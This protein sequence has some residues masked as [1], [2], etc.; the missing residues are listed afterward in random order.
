MSD[1]RGGHKIFFLDLAWD[2]NPLNHFKLLALNVHLH[3][4]GHN[5]FF[6]IFLSWVWYDP[7]LTYLWRPSNVKLF[8]V[9]GGRNLSKKVQPWNITQSRSIQGQPNPKNKH[10]ILF[11]WPLMYIL[12][13]FFIKFENVYNLLPFAIYWHCHFILLLYIYIYMELLQKY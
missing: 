4:R 11:L 8:R 9:L 10:L 6:Q 12:A 3:V 7:H 2:P 5:L 13:F 1:R